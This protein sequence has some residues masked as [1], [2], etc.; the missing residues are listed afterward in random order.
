MYFDPLEN[1]DE[2]VTRIFLI[3]AKRKLNK[4]KRK[5][6]SIGNAKNVLP[7]TSKQR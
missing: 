4:K 7:A 6:I 3:I 5:T 2:S 1:N